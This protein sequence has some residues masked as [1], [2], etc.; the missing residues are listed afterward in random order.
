MRVCREEK[1]VADWRQ[2]F[3]VFRALSICHAATARDDAPNYYL[4]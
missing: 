4:D 1:V 2:L 3:H